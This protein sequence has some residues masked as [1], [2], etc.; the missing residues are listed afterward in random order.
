[1]DEV[2]STVGFTGVAEVTLGSLVVV[3]M[4][5]L[6]VVNGCLD[7]GAGVAGLTTLGVLPPGG[8]LV[9]TGGLLTL[10]FT[11]SLTGGFL[12]EVLLTLDGSGN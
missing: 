11:G 3:E 5:F 9:V 10:G 7:T 4:A 1:M 8:R 2:T 6:L 12:S